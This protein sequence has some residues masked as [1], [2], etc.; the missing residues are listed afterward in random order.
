MKYYTHNIICLEYEEYIS[1]FGVEL[2]KSDKKREKITIYGRGGNSN[3]ILIDYEAMPQERR[4][5]VKE[6][7]GNPYEY[8]CKQPLVD[9]VKANYDWAAD[10]FYSKYVL[11]TGLKLPDAYVPKY[12]KAATWLKAIDF[13]TTDKRELKQQLNISI[14]AFW[15]MAGDLIRTKDVSLPVNP[16]RLKDKL[17]D[18]KKDGYPCMIE[19]FRFGNSNS[20]KVKDEVSEALLVQMI[21]HPHKHDDTIIAIKYNEWAKANG[22]EMICASTVGYRRKQ[23]AIL[24]T[25]S[26]DGSAINYNQFSKRIQ[27]ERPSA[28]LLLINSDDNVLDLYFRDGS[29]PY[30]RKTAYLVVDAFNDYILGYAF[31]ETNTIE[32]IKEAY[33][34]A[35][36]HVKELTG[37]TYL[38]H[39]IQTDHWAIDVKKEGDLAMFFKNQAHYTPATV[40]VAQAK[41]IERTFGT[42]WDQQLKFF[43]NYSGRNITANQRLNPDAVQI[44]KKDYPDKEQAPQVIAQFIDN[45]RQTINPKS[46]LS[47]QKEWVEAFKASE[48]S[49]VKLIDAEKRLQLFGVQHPHKN[50][51]SAA[52]IKVEIN[53]QRFAF[54]IADDLY[55]QNVGKTVQVTYDPYDMSQVLISDGRGL[56]FVTGEVHK[57]PSALADFEPGDRTLLNQRLDFKKQINKVVQES[58]EQRQKVLQRAHIDANSFLQAGVTIKEVSHKAQKVLTGGEVEDFDWRMAQ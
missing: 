18:F 25:L 52:G 49:K 17:K 13:F 31:G 54:D 15:T 12:A 51:I 35:I 41:Y 53:R 46:G 42:I 22:R 58:L 10:K 33:L 1:C 20:K 40:K 57:M 2:Y 48:K 38:W 21:A 6:K 45:M 16:R 39:Q 14:E 43:A 36:H 8:I 56:R 19:A 27:R 55:M 34:N 24:T 44:A 26:R 37:D 32:L 29:N 47:R 30:H 28:P 23:T 5:V 4:A 11:P 7:Y 3:P 9:Y 50:K